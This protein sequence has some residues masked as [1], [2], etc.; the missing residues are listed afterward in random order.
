MSFTKENNKEY[1][2]NKNLKFLRKMIKVIY[3]F[4]DVMCNNNILLEKE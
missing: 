3:F 4:A 1:I 2:L